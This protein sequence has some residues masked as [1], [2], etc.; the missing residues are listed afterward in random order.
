MTRIREEEDWYIHIS[1]VLRDVPVT[2][3][4]QFKIAA[5]AFDCIGQAYFKDVCNTVP[6]WSTPLV[7]QTCVRPIA[8]TCSSCL[9]G[10]SS[11][12][13]DSML[14]GPRASHKS[15]IKLIDVAAP[16][17]WN[18][19]PLHLRSPSISRGQFRAGLKTH[20]FN[21]AYTGLLRMFCFKSEAACVDTGWQAKQHATSQAYNRAYYGRSH[22]L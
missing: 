7:E 6:Q 8:V 19:L 12:D 17:V 20:I 9:T 1:P 13:E 21:Q 5:T 3:R 22:V 11:A 2:Q 16:T 4:I 15:A 18:S 14:S 10:H